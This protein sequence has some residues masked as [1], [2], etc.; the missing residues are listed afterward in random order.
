MYGS[1]ALGAA[2]TAAS[3][4]QTGIGLTA[5]PGKPVARWRTGSF[6]HQTDR[7]PCLMRYTGSSSPGLITAPGA[8]RLRKVYQRL[9]GAYP[10]LIPA[11]GRVVIVRWRGVAWRGVAW[12][13]VAWRDV[14]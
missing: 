10:R 5:H 3:E 11:A 14:A 8:R 9:S 13:G 7:G 4:R 1:E 12:R 6:L 2:I